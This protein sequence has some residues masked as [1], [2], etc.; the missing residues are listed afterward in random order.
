M[1]ITTNEQIL[2][3]AGMREGNR[4]LIVVTGVTS[5]LHLEFQHVNGGTWYDY[6]AQDATV[7]AAPGAAVVY[8][9]VICPVPRMRLRLVSS[10]ETE[11]TA[12]WVRQ[13]YGTF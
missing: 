9:D 8:A 13:I 11:W 4:Y 2:P 5:A 7:F 10:Q 1:Q 6:A 12:T 3:L